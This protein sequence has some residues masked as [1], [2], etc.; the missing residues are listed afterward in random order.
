MFGRSG[1]YRNPGLD[2]VMLATGRLLSVTRLPEVARRRRTVKWPTPKCHSERS[3]EG[4][5]ARNRHPPGCARIRV[6]ARGR[7]NDGRRRAIL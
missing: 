5:E 4:A 2:A 7:R 1:A 3:A 6:D